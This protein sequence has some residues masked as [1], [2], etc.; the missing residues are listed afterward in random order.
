MPKLRTLSAGK[1][2]EYTLK[3]KD[4]FILEYSGHPHITAKFIAEIKSALAG[5]TILGGFAKTNPPAGS[6]GAWLRDHSRSPKLTGQHGAHIAP[7]LLQMGVI[8]KAE[9]YSPVTLHFAP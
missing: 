3:G 1:E 6:F 4:G 8:Q 7:V 2:F 9:G 5:K